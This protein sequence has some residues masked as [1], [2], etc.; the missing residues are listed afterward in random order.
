MQTYKFHAH[1]KLA[2]LYWNRGLI[3]WQSPIATLPP[4]CIWH[5]Y[6]NRH[7]FPKPTANPMQLKIYWNLLS[8]FGLPSSLGTSG[9]T[10]IGESSGRWIFR[11]VNLLVWSTLGFLVP[12][13]INGKM[14]Q[15]VSVLWVLW[16]MA[17]GFLQKEAALSFYA[18]QR[19]VPLEMP[20]FKYQTRNYYYIDRVTTPDAPQ[21]LL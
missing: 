14:L 20:Q 15:N 7:T 10:S 21:F 13:P 8:H 11:L 16:G 6:G 2:Q 12:F 18:V 4:P 9:G 19:N 1:H 5:K 17:E 3:F